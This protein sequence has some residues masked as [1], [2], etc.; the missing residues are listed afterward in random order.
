VPP[1]ADTGIQLA[2]EKE[3]FHFFLTGHIRLG[4]EWLMELV[5]KRTDP[6]GAGTI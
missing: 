6:A 3:R 2:I 5:Q 4:S 1:S